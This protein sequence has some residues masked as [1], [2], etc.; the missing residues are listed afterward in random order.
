M[1]Q[2]NT[3]IRTAIMEKLTT[4]G[5]PF[6]KKDSLQTLKDTLENALNE[7]HYEK[8]G[9]PTENAMENET[10]NCINHIIASMTTKKEEEN[11][12]NTE[13]NTP[14]TIDTMNT[15]NKEDKNMTKNNAPAPKK[16]TKKAQGLIADIQTITPAYGDRLEGLSIEELTA[17]RR[18]LKDRANALANVTHSME[19]TALTGQYTDALDALVHT[20]Y[21]AIPESIRGSFNVH[22]DPKKKKLMVRWSGKSMLFKVFIQ[23]KGLKVHLKTEDAWKAVPFDHAEPFYQNGF[24]LPWAV[25]MSDAQFGEFLQW[26][27][28]TV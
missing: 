11:T 23:R 12:M 10:Q 25:K 18:M 24:N 8:Y 4:M 13:N 17:L 27:F 7:R 1:N 9:R 22:A 21:N 3:M 15:E 19:N 26:V 6:K 16:L 28:T 2:E 5:V 14:A 20:V